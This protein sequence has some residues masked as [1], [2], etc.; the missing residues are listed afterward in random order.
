MT[1]SSRTAVPGNPVPS[2]SYAEAARLYCAG[3]WT[4]AEAM[5]LA[6]LA[7][8]PGHWDARHLAALVAAQ[9]GRE[10]EAEVDFRAIIQ[11][12]PQ[13]AE[14]HSNLAGLL[15]NLGR[16]AEAEAL[17]RQT[18]DLD[19][20]HA[21]AWI[22]LGNLLLKTG[23][24][25]EAEVSFRQALERNPGL[26]AAYLGL[27]VLMQQSHRLDEA[28]ALIRRALDLQPDFPE[29][30]HN[31]GRLLTELARPQ[32]AAAAYR[33]VLELKPGHAEA[34][35]GLGVLMKQMG[36]FQEAEA[37]YREARRLAPHNPAVLYN[38]A[39]LLSGR[40]DAF[41]ETVEC[42]D[43]LL[44][45]APDHRYAQGMAAHSRAKLC[46]WTDHAATLERLA[47]GI[48]AGL[49]C[50]TP[51]SLMN[52]LDD[53]EAQ[54]RC[55]ALYAPPPFPDAGHPLP[56]HRHPKIRLA[57]ISPDF[58]NHPVAHLVV[59]LIESHDRARF[60]VVGVSLGPKVQDA[61]RQRLERGFD[62]FIDGHGVSDADLT[63]RLRD[64]EIDIAVDLAGHTR[65]ARPGLFARR[66]APIQVNYLGYPGTLGVDY[67]DYLLAD[68]FVVPETEAGAYA[69]RIVR[70]PDSFQCAAYRQPAATTPTRAELGLPE[71]GFVFCSFNNTYKIHPP[72]FDLW[73]RVLRRVEGGVLW[74]LKPHPQVED[75]LRC[76]AQAR[77]VAP[78]RLVF[79][80]RLPPPDYLARYRRA[81]L[82]LDTL[83]YNAGTTASDALWMGLPVLTQAGRSF[84]ARMGG[85]LLRAAG[86]PELIVHNTADYEALAV[87]LA[88]EPDTLATL[89]AKLERNL[90]HQPLFDVPRSA[91]TLEAAYTAM[92]E[93]WQRGAAP[94]H[95]AIEPLPTPDESTMAKHQPKPTQ[96]AQI[97]QEAARLYHANQLEAARTRLAKYLTLRPDDPE[98]LN[99]Q[100]VIAARTQ[101]YATAEQLLLKLIAA[102]P[103]HR[104][105]RRNLAIIYRDG[106]RAADAEAAYRH[107]LETEPDEVGHYLSLAQLLRHRGRQPEALDLYQRALALNPTQPGQLN[108][109]GNALSE[110]GRLAAA[111][112]AYRQSLAFKPDN[113][114]ALN[115]L[116]VTL[117]KALRPDEAE[118]FYRQALAFKPDYPEAW[119]NLGNLLK[120]E[121]KL[122]DAEAAYREA[123]RLKPDYAEAHNTL[124][125][126]LRETRRRA[127]AEAM[128]RRAIALKPDAATFYNELGNL[129]N[130]GNRYA[131]AEAAYLKALELKPD[132][133]EVHSNLGVLYKVSVRLEESE[134]AFRKAL[135]LRPEYPDAYS[136]LGN[137]LRYMGR[138]QEAEAAYR[139]ALVLDPNRADI[140]D[141]LGSLYFDNRLW[142]EA[143]ACFERT[144]A[145]KPDYPD[146]AGMA[147]LCRD[148]V[149]D[150][151][152]QAEL[153]QRLRQG[154]HAGYRG[155]PP[156]TLLNVGGD[157]LEQRLGAE[158]HVRDKYPEQ[159]APPLPR[160]R[161]DRIRIAYISPDWRDHPVAHLTADL[162][163]RHDRTRFEITAVALGQ[164]AADAWRTRVER[165]VDRFID[166]HGY[167]DPALAQQLRDL[168]ID[169]AVDLAGHTRNARTGLF[170]CR[171]APIQVNY[172]GHPGTLGAGYIDY[173]L[174]DDFVVPPGDEEFYVERVVR[175]PE[176][177]QSAALRPLDTP[178]PSR[179][180]L[181]LPER[182]FVFCC[183][184][185][186]YKIHP[187]IFEIWMRL[188]R[189]VPDSV[190]WLY[191]ANAEVETNLRREAEARGVD[192][193][194]LVFGGRK[195]RPEY[196]ARFRQADVF[197]D[198]LPYN[199][200]TT[201]ADALWMGLPVLT[202]PGRA[203]A[204]RMAGSLLRAAGLP[205][206]IAATPEAYEALALRLA[207]RP[208]ELAALKAK[209]ERHRA[210]QPLFDLERSRSHL[211]AA[212]VRMWEIWQA[213]GA[214]ESFAVPP[215]PWE[216]RPARKLLHIGGDSRPSVFSAPDWETMRLDRADPAA[217]AQV[218][219]GSLDAIVAQRC[220][221]RLY[222]QAVPVVL[223]EFRR[224]LAAGGYVWVEVPDLGAI[225]EW[226]AGDELEEEIPAA[227]ATPLDLI[228]GDRAA[229]HHTG[230]TAGAL[231]RAL[232][233]A[234]FAEVA[235]EQVGTWGL[236]AIACVERPDPRRLAALRSGLGME[237]GGT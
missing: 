218:A 226:I 168:E 162:L 150:W 114:E 159:P 95:L 107:L 211:E 223:G 134:A 54:R 117:R 148:L 174:A 104:E 66:A 5:A 67:M 84:A 183:F 53:P 163:E 197:L 3:R 217:L 157:P 33:R 221:Q 42:F 29:A 98:A 74:L 15:V 45:I 131:E 80:G 170:A 222:P 203:F 212:Y 49:P 97:Y 99:F 51:F 63:R 185:N 58:Q 8:N 28:E 81:D 10:A 96:A 14:A 93:H 68:A 118:A 155:S 113:P 219:T 234:G 102:Q 120:Q 111:E 175:L 188:L 145:L 37:E 41:V 69:E 171:V 86:L 191:Q 79:G 1:P 179:A 18:L 55:A 24:E 176:C 48:A 133:A 135:A 13:F 119:N 56:R 139:Q 85:S 202:L 106:G 192:P 165:A 17:Y 196:L 109:I 112:A 204:S 167:S 138:Q 16:N 193:A 161:H 44:R 206:L 22:N 205:E 235:V 30:H 108:T 46:D 71:T 31:L 12:F 34:H 173:L 77:R 225:A 220:L 164:P 136:N 194:R 76:E 36:R 144:L 116:A 7:A 158:I 11:T 4:E 216:V 82:F 182:G 187:P 19:P 35:N 101:D 231:E 178:T 160:H 232:R 132:Y 122:A 70:L 233:A 152:G 32:E 61:F 115:N 208:E 40:N 121:G 199:A 180:E 169:I 123:I 23:R 2:P 181:G 87:R 149:C 237:P 57:Y 184:N 65:N 43:E 143:L 75:N 140:H 229:P 147:V 146:S 83:P 124:G 195:P 154:V 141:N 64:L 128:Q 227:A 100:A 89:K 9:T 190:L 166:A 26:A 200:G 126:V 228:Y 52:A 94:T 88:T 224:M 213:G 137:L 60:E 130:D 236:R 27:G 73:M 6:L 210:T 47:R 90:R 59:D 186:T 105:A 207:T 78:E 172:L 215:L 209:L 198:T 189:Q 230:F 21:N 201:A 151:R 25:A 125:A 92:W 50:A 214:P 91:R 129:L 38:L 127:E 39:S 20:G 177:F 62:V 110:G 153:H 156:W 142:N 72:Q 103:A